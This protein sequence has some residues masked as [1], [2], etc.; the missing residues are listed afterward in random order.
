MNITGKT[1]IAGIVGNPVGHSL[2][3][4]IHNFLFQKFG[5]DAVYVP[6]EIKNESDLA[7][8][9]QTFRSAGFIGA[10]ITIPYKS[11]ILKY[12]DEIRE[13][14]QKIGAAN[15]LYWK[16]GKLCATT[17]DYN[18]FIKSL[19]IGIHVEKDNVVILGNGGTARTLAMLLADYEF[20]KKISLVARNIEKV[21]NLARE[22]NKKTNFTINCFSFDEAKDVIENADIIINCTPVGM[23][24]NIDASP[25]D[26][27][28]V[29]PNTYIYDAIYN[30]LETK[31][32]REARLKGCRTQNGLHMLIFQALYSFQYWTDISYERLFDDLELVNELEKILLKE[33]DK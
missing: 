7:S 4:K 9:V 27:S 10:N 28:L 14:S 21:K 26:I 12:V 33:F 24:P 17:T 16:D 5:I 29:N 11:E 6:F 1:K 15:T 31:L 25:I 8:F 30:P 32:L 2:S 20:S 3:P 13:V 23:S 18:G 19:P 22:I